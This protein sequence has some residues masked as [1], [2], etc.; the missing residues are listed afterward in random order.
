M[1]LS[2]LII[3]VLVTPMI[4]LIIRVLKGLISGL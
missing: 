4:T 1:V 3:T 2:R